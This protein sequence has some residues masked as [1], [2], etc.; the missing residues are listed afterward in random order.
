M[1]A[2]APSA[3]D[4]FV[5]ALNAM[6]PLK[7]VV[8]DRN[9]FEVTSAGRVVVSDSVGKDA[10]QV[11]ALRAM[12]PFLAKYEIFMREKLAALGYAGYAQRVFVR[13]REE[14]GATGGDTYRYDLNP[15]KNSV[16]TAVSE[17]TGLTAPP[18]VKETDLNSVKT[19]VPEDAGL[20][21]PPAVPED[22]GLSAPQA[23]PDSASIKR[24]MMDSVTTVSANCTSESNKAGD[25]RTGLNNDAEFV[26][27]WNALHTE[28][29]SIPGANLTRLEYSNKGNITVHVVYGPLNEADIT[30]FNGGA[31]VNAAKQSCLGGGGVDGSIHRAAGT[32]LLQDC[33]NID[34]V[35]DAN[36]NNMKVE[37]DVVRCPTGS[38]TMTPLNVNTFAVP[39]PP[40]HI[41]TKLVP[42]IMVKFI[43]HA[44]GPDCGSG[45][46][47]NVMSQQQATLIRSAYLQS[48]NLAIA[49]GVISIAFP[50]ISCGIYSCQAAG[51]AAEAAEAINACN[52]AALSFDR[53]LHI[54]FILPTHDTDN[55]AIAN[56]FIT[57]CNNTYG[58]QYA[59]VTAVSA[60]GSARRAAPAS[61]RA[62]P[63]PRSRSARAASPARGTRRGGAA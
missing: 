34:P 11:S 3:L 50:A 49:N 54:F 18:A 7:G 60:G 41:S 19:A 26:N 42:G 6:V 48:L 45:N 33:T 28:A 12:Y 16:K 30:K 9:I 2:S 37:D 15:Q 32:N 20:S 21:A 22:A 24:Q 62:R 51:V 10:S 40:M 58:Q 25:I 57:Q 47:N 52:A 55:I 39:Y 14:N 56:A 4:A 35:K 59:L 5:R 13:V 61:A 1:G 27:A 53:H 8:V 63:R 38:A 46:K 43:I 44:T 17:D 31:I 23:V 36:G 29:G